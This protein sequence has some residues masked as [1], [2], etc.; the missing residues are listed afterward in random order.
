MCFSVNLNFTNHTNHGRNGQNY[1]KRSLLGFKRLRDSQNYMKSFVSPRITKVEF[2]FKLRVTL[3]E[4][5]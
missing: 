3:R 4:I 1:E 5:V 2:E